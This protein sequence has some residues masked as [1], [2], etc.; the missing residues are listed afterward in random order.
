[1]RREFIMIIQQPCGSWSRRTVGFRSG[2][3]VVIQTLRLPLRANDGKAGQI[4]SCS[5]EFDDR[6]DLDVDG[7]SGIIRITE[8][9]FFDIGAGAPSAIALA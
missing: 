6:A 5:E 4:I 2:R 7:P 9:E 8:Q 1:M 3:R